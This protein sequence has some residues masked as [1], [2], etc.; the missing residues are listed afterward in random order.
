MPT[1]S[2]E[3]DIVINLVSDFWL[4]PG[5]ALLVLGGAIANGLDAL[6][7]PQASLAYKPGQ[8]EAWL[9]VNLANLSGAE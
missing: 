2:P 7:R 1:R 8:L 9:S 5:A 6:A 3:A 4:A